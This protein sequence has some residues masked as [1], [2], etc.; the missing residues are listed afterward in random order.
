VKNFEQK[1]W[2]KHNKE[3]ILEGNR[4]KFTQNPELLQK[5]RETVGTTLVEASPTDRIYGIGLTASDPRARS[6]KTWKGRNL[7]GE[8]LTE[9]REELL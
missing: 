9:L 3:I 6:R 1:K 2:E 8:T 7:L 4:H 5:L